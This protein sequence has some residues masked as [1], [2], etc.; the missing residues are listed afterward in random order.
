MPY[1]PSLE[2][3][4]G[5]PHVF[6]RFN[7]GAE[8]IVL[9]LLH[10]VMREQESQLSIAKRELIAFQ[11]SKINN[12]MYCAEAH[13]RAALEFGADSD[14]I[15]AIRKTP[16][17]PNVDE[18]FHSLLKYLQKVISAPQE[19]SKHDVASLLLSGYDEETIYHAN[20]IASTITMMNTL[21]N[22]VG[23]RTDKEKA[24]LEGR[25]L[26]MGY[27]VMIKQFSLQ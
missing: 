17:A 8:K 18:H 7:A 11:I 3:E 26:K 27:R 4:D 14:Q 2:I 12:C 1:L 6:A 5:I 13:A 22:G 20:L 21:V 19:L 15:I 25:M 16:S 10:H 9:E 23:L 24:A